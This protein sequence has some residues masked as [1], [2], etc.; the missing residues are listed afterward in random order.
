MVRSD[1]SVSCSGPSPRLLWPGNAR[2]V[3]RAGRRSQVHRPDVSGST[4]L[5]AEIYLGASAGPGIYRS[6][7]VSSQL[8]SGNESHRSAGSDWLVVCPVAMAD[9]RWRV[10]AGSCSDGRES[11]NRH[12][13]YRH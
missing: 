2:A 1:F 11:I 5:G 3:A 13:G 12:A 7:R 10:S 8:D 4:A 6:R 9:E